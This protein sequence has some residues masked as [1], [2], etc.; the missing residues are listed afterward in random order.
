MIHNFMILETVWESAEKKCEYRSERKGVAGA[1]RNET[2]PEI[3][4]FHVSFRM[5][6]KNRSLI[7]IRD[8]LRMRM[9]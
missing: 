6:W 7:L 9:T 5:F 4:L 1:V 2:I 8:F 3:K